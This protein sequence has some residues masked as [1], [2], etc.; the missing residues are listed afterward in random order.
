MIQK[1]AN[2]LG[3]VG[4]FIPE[5]RLVA[6]TCAAIIEK[7]HGE[8]LRQRLDEV[9]RPRARVETIAHDENKRWPGPTDIEGDL[10]AVN[11]GVAH[12]HRAASQWAICSCSLSALSALR[13]SFIVRL[14]VRGARTFESS[15]S[16]S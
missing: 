7:H 8:P 5:D 2:I 15:R 9:R 11:L 6:K 10:D 16:M 1:A 12:R 3:H 14:P 4:E 13:L